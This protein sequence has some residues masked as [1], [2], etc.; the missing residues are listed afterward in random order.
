MKVLKRD[1]LSVFQHRSWRPE[2][3]VFA[4]VSGRDFEI[5]IVFRGT[6]PWA[7]WGC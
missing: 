4:L 1:R 3:L 2:E 5:A 6:L 7:F